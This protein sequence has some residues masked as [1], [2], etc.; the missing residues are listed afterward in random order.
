MRSRRVIPARR[1]VPRRTTAKRRAF[2]NFA[3]AMQ[4]RDATN[5]VV[6]A[7]EEVTLIV[8]KDAQEATVVRNIN[9]L[10]TTAPMFMNYATMY[11]QYKLNA[12]R[13]GIEMTYIGND[14]LSNNSPSTAIIK[15]FFICT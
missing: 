7:Q 9:S 15:C 2:G 11:D 10:M 3:S 6:N 13:V 8:P 4:Q 1:T 5:I 14:L 12:V